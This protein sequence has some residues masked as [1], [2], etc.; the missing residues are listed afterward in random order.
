MEITQR[1]PTSEK[2][3]SVEWVQSTLMAVIKIRERTSIPEATSR[4]TGTWEHCT[5]T[6]ALD[7]HQQQQIQRWNNAPGSDLTGGQGALQNTS[8]QLT[9]T[10]VTRSIDGLSL[11]VCRL[12]LW[13][14]KL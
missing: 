1:H 10:N 13:A 9:Q 14:R 4:K 12:L 5:T 6:A 11:P 3:S 7:S 2:H 8:K